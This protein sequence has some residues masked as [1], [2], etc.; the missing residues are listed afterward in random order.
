MTIT[1]PATRHIITDF[2]AAIA[3]A[4]IK[5]GPHPA[6][7]V[8]NF[9]NER[10]DG[11]ERN[12]EWI[13]IH[14]LRYRKD[15]TRIAS[16]VLGWEA[17]H[18][19]LDETSEDHQA[20]LQKF[21]ADKDPE[22]TEE[23]RRS[24]LHEDQL[25]P[26]IITSDGFL[27]NGNR[28]KMVLEKLNH[29]RMKVVILPGVG[30]DGGPPTLEEIEQIENR[31]QLQKDGRAEYYGFDSAIGIR[32]K[33][34]NGYS[35]EAQLRDNAQ[36]ATLDK[37]AF[38]KAVKKF[39]DD[40]LKPLERVDEYL[41]HFGRPSLYPTVAEGIG[42]REGRWQAFI[43]FSSFYEKLKDPKKLL[44]MGLREENV[45]AIKDIAFKIIRKREF[46]SPI[47]KVHKIMRD[48]EKYFANDFAR[49]EL[50]KLINVPID[51]T[52]DKKFDKDGKE[53][54]ERQQDKIWGQINGEI[55]ISQVKKAI[56][57]QDY[58]EEKEAPLELMEAALKKL[59]HQ[60]MD[61]SAIALAQI[62]K[63]RQILKEIIETATD[64]NHKIYRHEKEKDKLRKKFGTLN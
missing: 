35:L 29:E 55:L 32:K 22:K 63:A 48:L 51:L 58:H 12:I 33:I 47:P 30:D 36:Y 50:Y 20:I 57:L 54:D 25:E 64:L 41:R 38:E 59:T 28:R 24:I 37:K 40:Y 53:F 52:D 31:Y 2:A 44:K 21:L 9:R 60:D 62:P 23:L 61:T 46:P 49:K 8:I 15:N 4:R 45:G 5:E 43:D 1:K 39:K 14:L 34:Q 17:S 26:A 18:Y 3:E 11:F 10:Q 6:K 13:P 42:D 16:D 19:A 56:Q 27:I 7:T